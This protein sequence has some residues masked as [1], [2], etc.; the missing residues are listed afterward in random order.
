MSR[1]DARGCGGSW[2][3]ERLHF[4]ENTLTTGYY[5]PHVRIVSGSRRLAR[6]DSRSILLALL[7]RLEGRR[8]WHQRRRYGILRE[9]PGG[10]KRGNHRKTT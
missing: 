9:P 3:P 5:G 7:I 2:R 8:D 1:R 4:T 10:F 6:P